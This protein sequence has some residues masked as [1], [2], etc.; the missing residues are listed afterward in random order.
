MKIKRVEC[1]QFAGLTGKEI[2]FSDGLNLWIG[3]NETGKSTVAELIYHL[4][5]RDIKLDKRKHK[6]FIEE[7]F[8]KQL[9]GPQGDVI[10]GT[11]L[12]ETEQ[13]T[14]KLRKEWKKKESGS[15]KLFIPPDSVIISEPDQ[16]GEVLAKELLYREGVYNEIIFASQ[17]RKQLAVESILRE[18]PNKKEDPLTGA[19]EDF[20][21]ILTRAALETGGVALDKL[22]KG[23]RERLKEYDGHWDFVNGLPE[24][25]KRWSV[26]VGKILEAYYEME[27]VKRAQEK[28]KSAED[29]LAGE[30][31]VLKEIKEKKNRFEAERENFR[32][33]NGAIEKRKIYQT[34]LAERE[35]KKKKAERALLEWPEAERQLKEAEELEKKQETA[36]FQKLYEKAEAAEREY[37]E[38][39]VQ[40]EK[41]K[42]VES[43][44]L[45]E[46]ALCQK[47]RQYAVGKLAGLNLIAQLKELG[48]HKIELKSMATGEAL[49]S[50]DGLYKLTE[51]VE[52]MIP[53]IME[54][55][56]MP[57]GVDIEKIRKEITEADEK[58]KA[59]FSKYEVQTADE[60]SG[61]SETYHAAEREKEKAG[62]SFA[63]CLNDSAWERYTAEPVWENIRRLKETYPQESESVEELKRQIEALCGSVSLGVFKGKAEKTLHDYTESYQSVPELKS[64]IKN[65]EEEI[66]KSREKLAA[67]ER[68]P[69]QYR[70]IEEPERYM[71]KLEK[72]IKSFDNELEQYTRIR[73]D[74]LRNLSERPAEE[75]AEELLEKEAEFERKKTE[76]GH[77]KHIFEVFT[78]MKEA[79]GESPVTDIEENF[80]KYLQLISDG[81]IALT[82]MDDRLSV[83]IASGSHALTYDILS[84]G[85]KDTISLAFRLAMLEHIFP[86]GGGLAVFDDPFTEMDPKRVKQA[87][88]L[89]EKFAEHNQVIFLTCDEKYQNLMTAN[90]VR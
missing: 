90:I 72:Q 34:A 21:S 14:Y 66:E 80:R 56:L 55:K 27:D 54:M 59:L 35:E 13:G 22:E 12:F 51:A 84:E 31:T 48:A 74:L 69:E 53:G 36:V 50:E 67:L 45:E 40:I 68:I 79:A 5:F 19:R 17:K 82:S 4:L 18:L 76:Y 7:Y 65:L 32:K 28:A 60:L 49:E 62:Q 63:M 33:Y 41:L 89:I 1:D 52:I 70:N 58:L 37:R 20:A 29:E 86:A 38:K 6:E 10:D 85:T 8:P 24:R 23:L 73:D 71:E 64:L 39:S 30:E 46:A 83:R 9:T 81:R 61:L 87:C 42:K 44:D 77:W 2:S 3:E 57:Q 88:K 43:A 75:Y 47:R 25:N 11:L 26:G 16:I 78:E 15:C